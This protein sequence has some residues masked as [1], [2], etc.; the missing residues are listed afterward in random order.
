LKAVTGFLA[1]GTVLTEVWKLTHAC[2]LLTVTLTG[3]ASPIAA[4]DVVTQGAVK[5]GIIRIFVL[6]VTVTDIRDTVT[7]LTVHGLGVS[8]RGP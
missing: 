6:V 7:V 3:T 1:A 5:S 8:T 2:G 4:E